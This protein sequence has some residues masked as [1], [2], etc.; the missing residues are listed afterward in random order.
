[1]KK[2]I[3]LLMLAVSFYG[4]GQ[5]AEPVADVVPWYGSTEFWVMIAGLGLVALEWI[6]RVVPTSKPVGFLLSAI[7][8]IL[9]WIINRVPQKIK[10]KK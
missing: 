7:V 10:E 9:K 4:F 8:S 6:I 1:M 2:L 5:A 3:V